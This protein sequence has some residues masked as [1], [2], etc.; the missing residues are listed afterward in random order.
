VSDRL[1]ER[2]EVAVE[3]AEGAGRITLSHFQKELRVER[4]ADLS[5]VTI[6]DREAEEH[7]FDVLR[8][9]YPGDGFLGEERGEVRGS[10]G[11]RWI[12]DPIDGTKSFIQGVPLYGVLVAL[13]DGDR[14]PVVGVICLPALAETVAAARGEGCLWN[15][16]RAR[17]SAVERIEDACLAFTALDGFEAPGRRA[18]FE[19]LERRVRVA[20]GWGDCYGHALVATGRADVMVD[21]VL[22][23]WD[24][25]A[26]LPIVEEAGGAFFDW[27]GARTYRGRSGISTNARLAAAVKDALGASRPLGPEPGGR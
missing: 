13:E 23:D 25:A 6:A 22:S 11:W 19:R 12:V 7:I 1:R 14:E 17:V 21:P 15:G 2:L 16:R 26:L 27:S 5:P 24:C 20:R 4:K 10:S 9:R 8:K 3:A 18:A